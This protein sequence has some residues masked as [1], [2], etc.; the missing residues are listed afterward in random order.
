MGVG[1]NE[2]EVNELSMEE[3]TERYD[4]ESFD[5]FFERTGGSITHSGECHWTR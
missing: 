2:G 3:G 5:F 4:E 1:R